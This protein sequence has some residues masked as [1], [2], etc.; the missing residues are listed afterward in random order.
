MSSVNPK[1][2]IW[3][4]ETAGLSLEEAAHTL[5]IK[6][7]YNMT[8]VDRL[9]QIENGEAILTRPLLLKM[10]K[11]YHRSLL[12][13]YLAEPPKKGNRGQDFRTLPVDYSVVVNAN[14][15][16]LIRDIQAR[17]S[18]VR[19]V[20]E[21]DDDMEPLQFINSAKI[22]D[23]I[24]SV[25]NSIRNTIGFCLA[26]YRN[27][28]DANEA[29]LY[30]RD[31]VEA[32]GIF[33]LL[34][35][36]LGSYHSTIPVDVFRGFAISDVIAPFIILNDHD[37]KTAWSFSLL[38]ELTHLWLGTTG[39]S[40]MH[41][42]NTIEKF[43]NDVAAEFLLPKDDIKKIPLGNNQNIEEIISIIIKFANDR[44]ISR[45]VVA[46]RLFRLGMINKKIWNNLNSR[47]ISISINEKE[48]KKLSEN[49]AN[50][51]PSYYVVRQ[52][53]LGKSILK[54]VDRT[55]REGVL[56]PIKAAKVLGVKPRNLHP[57]L[58]EITGFSSFG[59]T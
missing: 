45:Q 42:E 40:D 38:H 11:Q 19:S 18:L 20:L 10:S 51:G 24:T 34:I 52:H 25:L 46:Y 36:D 23:G 27:K 54:F 7:A 39:V 28:K 53:R 37:A 50:S 35:G 43:C 47:F 3:A 22:C 2:L 4:R 32:L 44:H 26:D 55:L 8:A 48:N 14:L 17:Q 33:V 15:D 5:G 21:D 49:K 16:A 59:D 9:L 1:I 29:F 58:S 30:L 56:T 41:S 13:F 57:L 6:K 31:K 12:N